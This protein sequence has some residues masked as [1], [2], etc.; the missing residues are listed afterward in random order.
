MVFFE[1]TDEEIYALAKPIIEG[2]NDGANNNN[3]KLFSTNFSSK[4]LNLVGEEKFNKQMEE[5]IPKN[6]ELGNYSFLGCIRRESGVTVVY[7]Q[8]TKKKKGELLGQLLL[9][10]ESGEIKVFYAGIQ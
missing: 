3:Y 7:K 4:M 8:N 1:H 10:E 9:N 5:N 6:G 2:M